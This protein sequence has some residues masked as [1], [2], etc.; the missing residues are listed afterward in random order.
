MKI[1]EE[2]III[3]PPSVNTGKFVLQKCEC[4]VGAVATLLKSKADIKTTLQLPSKINPGKEMKEGR[5]GN[6]PK[7][8][9]IEKVNANPPDFLY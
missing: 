7:Q 9:K 2:K 1:I 6:Q 4:K 8:N 3:Y 5:G